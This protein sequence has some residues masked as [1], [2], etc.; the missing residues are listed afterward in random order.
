[1]EFKI[2][3]NIVMSKDLTIEAVDLADAMQK[4]TDIMSKPI[5]RD[6]L[7]ITR[8]YFDEISPI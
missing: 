7:T 5:K 6:E 3:A 2:R 1:M 8:F 4:A